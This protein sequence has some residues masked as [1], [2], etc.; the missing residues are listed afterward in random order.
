[1]IVSAALLSRH[2]D[3]SLIRHIVIVQALLRANNDGMDIL[4]LSLGGADGWTESSA[5]VVASKIARSGKVV[6]IAAGNDGGYGSWYTSGPG[7]GIDVIS[8]ASVNNLG[9]PLQ[10]ATVSGV[11]PA[12]APIPYYKGLPLNETGP[13]P[14]YSV[15]NYSTVTDDA[16]NP[17]PADTPDLS[18]YLVLIRRGSCTFVQKLDNAAAKG[19]KRF[20]I[21]N[22]IEGLS[23]IGVG[24]Y[25]AVLISKADG[26]YLVGQF[27]A[28]NTGLRITFPQTGASYSYPDPNGGLVS[29]FTSYG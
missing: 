1:M 21:Y 18:S 26:E 28:K 22:N 20:F 29:D 24:D 11:T 15:S 4:T 9:I 6:T 19:A 13:F 2:Y 25:S 8:V 17:L 14:L 12:H 16:C 23:G 3:F 10:N 27:A 7:N 5:S